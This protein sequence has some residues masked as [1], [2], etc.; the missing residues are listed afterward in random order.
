MELEKKFIYRVQENDTIIS[1]CEKFN[2]S[3]DN[4]LRNNNEIPLYEGEIIEITINDFKIYNV[5]PTD[6]I[7]LISKKFN[8]SVEEIKQANSLTSDKLFIG[9]I[10]KIYNKKNTV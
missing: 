5:Q 3:K 6:T 9:Q 2:T 8:V 7:H 4:I 10:L 1:I